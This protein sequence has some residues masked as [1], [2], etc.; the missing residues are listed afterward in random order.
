MNAASDTELLSLRSTAKKND[1]FAEIY[2]RHG[3]AVMGFAFRLSG[4]RSLAEDLCQEVFTRLALSPPEKCTTL[5]P[6]LLR[7]T[8]NLFID[9]RRRRMLDID[10]MRDLALW[11][12]A[13]HPSPELA[14]DGSSKLGRVEGALQ[15]LPLGLREAIVLVCMQELSAAEAAEVLE[16]SVEAVRQ[17]VARGRSRL[18]LALQEENAEG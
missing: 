5:R 15:R 9:Q 16:T 14:F 3:D 10:R 8:R 18:R 7:V 6:W 2:R 1:A 13:S 11:P 17:R 12:R 4:S